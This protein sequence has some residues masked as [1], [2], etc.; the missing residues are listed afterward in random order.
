MASRPKA[1]R[2][3]NTCSSRGIEVTSSMPHNKLP[4]LITAN[5]AS[6]DR[7]SAAVAYTTAMTAPPLAPQ[8][9]RKITSHVWL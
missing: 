4:I 1:P 7:R 6:L 9:I 3:P 2:T 8:M 5:V